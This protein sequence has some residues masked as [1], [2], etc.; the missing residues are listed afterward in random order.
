[1]KE[2]YLYFDES[3]NLGESGKYFVIACILTENPKALENK[4]KKTLLSIKT[5]NN[6]LKVE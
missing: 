4:M 1:M 3:G 5:K 6:G 2:Y